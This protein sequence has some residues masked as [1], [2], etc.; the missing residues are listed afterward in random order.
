MSIPPEV[1]A[2]G[3][4]PHPEGGWYR[5]TWTSPVRVDTPGGTRPSATAILYLLDAV[6]ARHRVASAELWLWHTG[7][8]VEL[9]VDGRP[10]VLDAATPQRTVPAHAWQSARLLGPD[11]ALVSCVVSPGFDFADFELA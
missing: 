4:A 10:T 3:L 9:T 6:S 11:P 2:H 5:R 1:A 7:S 8:A